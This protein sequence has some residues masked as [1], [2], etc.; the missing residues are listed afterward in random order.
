MSHH[1]HAV[2]CKTPVPPSKLMCPKHWAMVPGL[3]RA[4]VCATYRPGQCD[5]MRPSREWLKA[6]RLAINAV[7]DMERG[8]MTR[9][10][11]TQEETP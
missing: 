5:D 1:C 6:A 9:S 4:S 11:A 8:A 7:R 10:E 2:G 3:I